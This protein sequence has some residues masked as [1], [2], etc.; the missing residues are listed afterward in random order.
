MLLRWGGGLLLAA[1]GL[2]LPAA[3]AA[4]QGLPELRPAPAH[5]SQ[6]YS[7]SQRLSVWRLDAPQAPPQ[8][9][10]VQLELDREAL[11]LAGFALGQRVLMLVWDGRALQ[12]QRH[13]RLPAEVDV[14]R[15]LRDLCLVYWPAAALR[16]ALPAGWTLEEG[17]DDPLWQRRLLQDGQPRLSLG[18]R[19]V[20]AGDSRIEILNPT[21]HYRLI[22]ESRPA[23]DAP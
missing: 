5:L 15:M 1:M 22:I 6:A 12:V 11:R 13:P 10:D 4:A 18:W 21:E 17:G 14:A 9:V 23:G 19:G 7:L 20:L 2:L 8:V 3:R 16:A